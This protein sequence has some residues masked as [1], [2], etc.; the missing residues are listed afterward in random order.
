[1]ITN[2]LKNAV[3]VYPPIPIQSIKFL[4]TPDPIQP[5]PTHSNPWMDPIHVHF[6]VLNPEA[7]ME[8]VNEEWVQFNA[9]YLPQ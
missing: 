1:M 2:I 3:T 4:E 9:P 5:N 7:S 6:Y 8:W